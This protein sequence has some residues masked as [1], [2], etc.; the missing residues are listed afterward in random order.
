M[1]EIEES[2]TRLY[3]PRQIPAIRDRSGQRQ[4]RCPIFQIGFAAAVAPKV[5][6]ASV[7]ERDES[8]RFCK[9]RT[10]IA[11]TTRLLLQGCSISFTLQANHKQPSFE[12]A[13]QAEC[14][15]ITRER[16]AFVHGCC[17]LCDGNITCLRCT[18]FPHTQR[19]QSRSKPLPI[20][21][22]LANNK[23]R[24]IVYPLLAPI[25]LS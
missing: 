19:H 3:G 5:G 8:K 24:Y 6:V 11:N 12:V 7:D 9:K 25:V 17:S 4:S 15:D 1:G 14:C 23:T 2:R 20:S 16:R 18:C 22:I 13:E 10:A 21:F